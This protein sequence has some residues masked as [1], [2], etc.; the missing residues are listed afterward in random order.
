MFLWTYIC[1]IC[2]QSFV[3]VADFLSIDS[4]SAGLTTHF[5]Q[6]ARC[7]GC[8]WTLHP[9]SWTCDHARRIR[10]LELNT[11]SAAQETDCFLAA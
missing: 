1:D 10:S 9:P 8:R 3:S 7:T 11:F 5:P 6:S 2:T 4:R